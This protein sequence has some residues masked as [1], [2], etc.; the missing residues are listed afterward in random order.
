MIYWH[1]MMYKIKNNSDGFVSHLVL[2]V[3]LLGVVG[4]VSFSGHKV[5][6]ANTKPTKVPIA[7]SKPEPGSSTNGIP[8]DAPSRSA[9]KVS[10]QKTGSAAA[11][12]QQSGAQSEPTPTIART[13]SDTGVW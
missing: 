11:V 6:V 3:I 10:I 4:L 12:V 1:Y 13:A 8:V 7:A 5:W 9:R 2:I